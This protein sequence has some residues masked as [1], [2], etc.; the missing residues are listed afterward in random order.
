MP[1]A[2]PRRAS[3]VIWKPGSLLVAAGL[4]AG[5]ALAFGLAALC[6]RLLAPL[7]FGIDARDPLTFAAAGLL[8]AIVGVA[9]CLVPAARASRLDPVR[10]LHYE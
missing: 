5:L 2:Q 4:T 6:S 7:L 10:A 3:K 9:A 1:T 8:L